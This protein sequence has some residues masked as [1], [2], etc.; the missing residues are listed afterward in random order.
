MQPIQL[1]P[2][3]MKSNKSLRN[4]SVP[5]VC[6]HMD[7]TNFQQYI[8]NHCPTRPCLQRV[9]AFHQVQLQPSES[10][11][12]PPHHR[13]GFITPGRLLVPLMSIVC[14]QIVS[15]PP[16]DPQPESRDDEAVV[17]LPWIRQIRVQQNWPARVGCRRASS[18]VGAVTTFTMYPMC[19]LSACQPLA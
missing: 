1:N 4:S 13:F 19:W 14:I 3:I 12:R 8:L 6:W 10:E 15:N 17:Y 18:R 11:L 9:S 2:Y 7:V 16:L 5:V